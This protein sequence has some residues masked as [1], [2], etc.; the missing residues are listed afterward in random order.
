[1]GVLFRVPKKGVYLLSPQIPEDLL[2]LAK[3]EDDIYVYGIAEDDQTVG[4]AVVKASGLRAELL[5]YYVVEAYRGKGIGKECFFD[6]ITEFHDRGAEELTAAIYADTDRSLVHLLNRYRPTFEPLSVCQAFFPAKEIGFVSELNKPSK[7][8]VPLHSCTPEEL[9]GLQESLKAEGK[10]I[11]DVT[12]DG[13]NSMIS[14]VYKKDGKALGALLFKRKSANEISLSFAGSVAKDPAVMSDMLCF[15]ASMI[16]EL[17]DGVIVSMSIVE[18][19][20]KEVMLSLL[21]EVKDLEVVDTKLAVISLSYLDMLRER[22]G[23]MI[24]LSA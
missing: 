13:Y 10:D 20:M 17:D 22:V 2:A 14:G 3:S 21:K 18:P 19:R 6:L 4:C 8:T 12:A 23:M 11:C 9:A 15:S 16:R 7:Y 1:M 5:W 24:K